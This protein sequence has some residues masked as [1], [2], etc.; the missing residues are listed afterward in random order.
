[1][2]HSLEYSTSTGVGDERHIGR[3]SKGE[4]GE[5]KVSP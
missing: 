3:V 2:I 4:W 1:M 5:E